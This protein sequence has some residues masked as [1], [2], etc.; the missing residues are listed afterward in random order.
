[1]AQ[2]TDAISAKD[3]YIALSTDGNTWTNVS[4]ESAKISPGGGE[5]KHGEG[6]TF[7]G[8]TAVLTRGK[9]EPHE[10]TISIF[11]R[12]GGGSARDFVNDAYYNN[13]PL[14]VRFAVGGN[15]SGN[16]MVTS[17]EGIVKTPP[18]SEAEAESA[19]PLMLEWDFI[20]P[21]WTTSTIT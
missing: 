6:Y 1:M 17:D 9:R 12:E 2:L 19:D 11:Y 8:D 13:T 18:F 20:T 10:Y 14:Y 16:E 21:D 7:D 15:S 3:L 5:R 4:G